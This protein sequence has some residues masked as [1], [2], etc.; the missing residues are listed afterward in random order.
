ESPLNQAASPPATEPPPRNRPRS[1]P[2][3]LLVRYILGRAAARDIGIVNIAAGP[4]A[5][6]VPGTHAAG[7]DA[8]GVRAGG[9]T[10]RRGVRTGYRLGSRRCA[11]CLSGPRSCAGVTPSRG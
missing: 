5:R 6:E 1:E 3:R 10:A 2:P 11:T 4:A 7:L 9:V 8:A